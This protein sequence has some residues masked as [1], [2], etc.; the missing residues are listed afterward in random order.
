MNFFG[1]G[2]VIMIV[3]ESFLVSSRSTGPDEVSKFMIEV[4][5]ALHQICPGFVEVRYGE[6]AIKLTPKNHP[7][8]DIRH[9]RNVQV[10]NL[11]ACC[12]KLFE[13]PHFRGRAEIYL[14]QQTG[15]W[16]RLGSVAKR[17]CPTV[18]S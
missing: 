2:L 6:E 10:S 17:R 4:K 8:L 16:P 1:L 5:T 11:G 14:P 15:H 3:S 13:K 18:K 9:R 12:F 7:K